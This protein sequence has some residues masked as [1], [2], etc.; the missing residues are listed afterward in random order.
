MEKRVNF[1]SSSLAQIAEKL[2]AYSQ[3]GEEDNFLFSH[4]TLLQLKM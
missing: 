3:K 2:L 4:T 1:L